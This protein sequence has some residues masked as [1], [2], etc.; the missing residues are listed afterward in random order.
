MESYNQRFKRITTTTTY[1][2]THKVDEVRSLWDIE[3]A[4]DNFYASLMEKHLQAAG[5]QDVITVEVTHSELSHP[6]FIPPQR[7]FNFNKA[8][9][10]N[11]LFQVSQSNAT[12]LLDGK[13]TLSVTVVK[14]LAGS[15]KRKAPETCAEF[16]KR[17]Q[18]VITINNEDTS[19]GYRALFLSKYHTD[20]GNAKP[21]EWRAIREDLRSVQYEGG[22]DLATS[23]DL[24]FHSPLSIDGIQKAQTKLRGEYQ[25]IVIDSKTRAQLFIGPS[26]DKEIYLEF[27]DGS[28]G[29]FNSIINIHGYFNRNHY[30]K[31]CNV[32][33]NDRFYHACPGACKSCR[34]YPSC[35]LTNDVLVCDDCNIQFYG[36]LC[37]QRHLSFKF[38]KRRRKCTNCLATYI[39]RADRPH[40]CNKG[41]C[42]K[43][44]ME[45][46]VYPHHCFITPKD[47]EKLKEQDNELKIFVAYDIESMQIKKDGILSHIP[48]LLISLTVCDEC[49]NTVLK[50]KSE[51]SC[52]TC[53]VGLRIYR[54]EDCVKRFCDTIYNETAKLAQA[55]G[56]GVYAFAHNSKGYDGHFVLRDLFPRRFKQEPRTV[57]TG[58]K[59]LKIE[60]GNVRFMDSLSFLLLPLAKLPNVF[61]LAEEKGHFPHLFNKPENLTYQ[62]DLPP[63]DWFA[64]DLLKPEHGAIVTKW[65]KEMS[66][67][68]YVFNMSK[69]LEKY[70]QSDVII[71]LQSVMTFRQMFTSITGIDPYTR[72]FTLASVGLETFRAKLLGVNTIGITPIEG[73]GEVKLFSKS[74]AAYIDMVK[75]FSKPHILKEQ[76]VGPYWVD[77]LVPEEKLIYEFLGC[78]WHGCPS[79]FPNR[80]I[81]AS[82]G[83]SHA[84][85]YNK[86]MEKFKYLRDHGYT[87]KG[88]FQCSLNDWFRINASQQQYYKT[89]IGY[90]CRMQHIGRLNIRDAFFGGR[91]N[92]IKFTHTITEGETVDYF[93]FTSLYPTVLWD[94]EF[95]IGHPEVIT[96]D[97][98]D[99]SEYFGFIKC[100][101]LPPQKLHIPVLPVR[102]DGKL[103]FPL[104]RAC[105]EQRS[106]TCTHEPRE[107]NLVGTWTTM[108]LQ[109]AVRNGYEI[110]E[111]YEV[112]HYTQRDGNLFKEYIKLWMKIKQETSGWP[113]WVKT[114][115]DKLSYISQYAVNQ[116][117]NLDYNNIIKNTGMRWIAKIML[118]SF[119]GKLAQRPNLTKTVVC[120]DYGNYWRV[121][122]DEKLV[123]VGEVEVNPDVMLI[124]YRNKHEEDCSPGNTNIGIAAFVTAYARLRLLKE[125]HRIEG[126]REGRVLYFDTDSIIFS[127]YAGEYKPKVGDYLGQMTDEIKDA[128]GVGSKIVKFASIGPKNYAYTVRQED[129]TE[130][131]TIK[132]K[133]IHLNAKTLNV[134]SIETI[135]NLAINYIKGE[136]TTVL[137]P[138][139]QIQATKSHNV[140]SRYFNKIYRAVSEKRKI[141]GNNTR[142]YGYI[143]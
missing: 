104:C 18:S 58:K 106:P 40:Q 62:G 16:A 94:S 124:S 41:Y 115:K 75:K 128:Y 87:V 72:N 28:P 20:H 96:E 73:Y 99:I 42:Q 138:Q 48:N 38:C 55:K 15:G 141:V 9:F 105:S 133:G 33:F 65:H 135:T 31:H 127:S 4:I 17:K 113:L 59:I 100:K 79:C 123:M 53:G 143:E 91:T 69:D 86:T 35:S 70:C 7:R 76:R 54:G 12:F 117:I 22:M 5:D 142:P 49:Y 132:A 131:T 56:G 24:D 103:L 126:S 111:I 45:Y 29:H 3:E 93:D 51:K 2:V 108:E 43:C 118:N 52:P 129:G 44:K 46:T 95:F 120:L 68:G 101:I 77:G 30:C 102:L 8:E 139:F 140:E 61:G 88:L 116:G 63:L 122:N 19:C 109:E 36:R 71:L 57:L 1:A 136:N 25:I 85:N 21:K 39:V 80:E 137:A 67:A 89:R 37:M 13:L 134:I 64:V 34:G 78:Y 119:W 82:N 6:I 27:E 83:N 121:V 66:D 97:F 110:I 107:R 32:G 114:E 112:N 14:A 50:Q 92:N 26:A 98:G 74:G 23:L 84:Q 90:Y 60:I 81:L 130:K 10:L 125:I 11:S 47:E